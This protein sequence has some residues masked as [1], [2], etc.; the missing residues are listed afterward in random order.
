[1]EKKRSVGVTLFGNLYIISG[2]IVLIL[3][4]INISLL[5]SPDK[6]EVMKSQF[7]AKFSP[8]SFNPWFF[9]VSIIMVAVS[10][11]CLAIGNGLLKLKETARKWVIYLSTFGIIYGLIECFIKGFR[12]WN[13]IIPAIIIYFFTRPK[14]RE[15]FK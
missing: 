7:E 4:V 5:F 13:F 12:A 9:V 3:S 8:L 10:I 6:L 15:Q 1:M 14:V 2:I 11:F